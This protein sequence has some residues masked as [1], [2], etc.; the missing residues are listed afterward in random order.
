MNSLM[1]VVPPMGARTSSQAPAQAP[2]TTPF[3]LVMDLSDEFVLFII[4]VLL[5]LMIH[6]SCR[7][8]VYLLWHYFESYVCS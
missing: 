3:F 5:C 4:S 2:H 1:D 7:T 6:I 8:Y